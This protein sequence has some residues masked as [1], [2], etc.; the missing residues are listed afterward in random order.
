MD[1]WQRWRPQR[2]LARGHQLVINQGY[3]LV[4]GSDSPVEHDFTHLSKLINIIG[5]Q[6]QKAGVQRVAIYTP[7]SIEY[8]VTIFGKRYM[9][10][11]NAQG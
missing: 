3:Y 11:I 5:S 7:N 1:C 6:L 8:L 9:C 2:Y 10:S 4:H